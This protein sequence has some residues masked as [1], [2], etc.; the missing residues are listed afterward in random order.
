MEPGIYVVGW[1]EVDLP[2]AGWT[3]ARVGRCGMRSI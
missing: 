1:D 2:P 3:M